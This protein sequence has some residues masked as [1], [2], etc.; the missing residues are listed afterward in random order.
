METAYQV[1]LVGVDGLK[2]YE[3]NSRMHSPDQVRQIKASM[4]EFGWT[5]PI[6]ADLTD[7]MIVAGH[8][9]VMAATELFRDDAEISM[10]GG[11]KLPRG[12]VPVIDCAGWSAAQRRAYVIADNKLAENA[13]WDRDM[14]VTEL[15]D[16]RAEDF[17]LTLMGFGEVELNDLLAPD[18]DA[19]KCDPDDIP[20]TP[21]KP[22]SKKGDLWICGDHRVLCGDAIVD[23]DLD[24]LLA[25]DGGKADYLFTDPPYLMNF[26]DGTKSGGKG[27]KESVGSAKTQKGHKQIAND[28]M[29]KD[30]GE[31]FLRDI[32]MVIKARVRGSWYV[33]FYRLGVH[34]LM[35]AMEGVGLKWRNLIIWKK[36]NHSMSNSDHKSI[37]EPML[38]GFADDYDAVVY[39]WNDEHTFYG[40]KMTLDFGQ[41]EIPSVWEVDRTKKNALHPTVKPVALVERG[42]LNSSLPGRTWLD[43]F[44]GS[45]T[46]LIAC[47]MTGR[48]A[49]IM[50]LEPAYVDVIVRRYHAFTGKL[51]IHAVTGKPFPVDQFAELPEQR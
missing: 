3:R 40:P 8:G 22:F 21:T 23:A 25:E 31:A 7:G 14:L 37:W 17:D 29:S 32:A 20:D 43:I 46:T 48:K 1:Q 11:G 38:Y 30:D 24:L 42:I 45:G 10:P 13:S 44:G 16:L 27:W 51:P 2:P 12:K 4:V 6:L 5:N 9:R 34:W 26:V 36:N 28:K 49:R 35:H 47:Q 15:L 50:E 18:V 41:L 33:T 19:P 39:G